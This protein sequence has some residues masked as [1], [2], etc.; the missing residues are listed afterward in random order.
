MTIYSKLGEIEKNRTEADLRLFTELCPRLLKSNFQSIYWRYL[1][2]NDKDN[3][4]LSQIRKWKIGPVYFLGI[5]DTLGS[6]YK[7]EN[8]LLFSRSLKLT[9]FTGFY[10]FF[11]TWLHWCKLVS[12][13]FVSPS[14]TE[15]IDT[16]HLWI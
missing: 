6:K 3:F 15:M 16:Q 4:Y 9:S 11:F 10:K 1:G 8:T 13:I 2:A 5:P 12:T 14:K 7:E